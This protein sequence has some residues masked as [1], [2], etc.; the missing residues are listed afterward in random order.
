MML[1]ATSRA[2][3]VWIN[4]VGRALLDSWLQLHQKYRNEAQKRL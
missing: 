2:L 4:Q 3:K 1:S